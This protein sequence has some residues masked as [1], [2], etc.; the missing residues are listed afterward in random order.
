M[1]NKSYV[2]A[3]IRKNNDTPY[4]IGIGINKRYKAKHRVSVPKEPHKI[5]FLYK[6]LDRK[7]ATAYE[8]FWIAVYGR[9]DLGT[10]ILNNRTAGGE[11]VTGSKHSDES[12]RKNAEAHTGSKNANFGKPRTQETKDK[13]AASL[14]GR[15]LDEARKKKISE[16]TKAAMTPEICAKISASKKGVK[17]NG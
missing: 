13:I 7:Q 14:K 15:P 1:D 10:G 6:D 3:Y 16:K 2:Y 12:K 5:K 9:K 11:G 17:K 8:I 4:Y